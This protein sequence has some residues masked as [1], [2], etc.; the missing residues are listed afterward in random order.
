MVNNELNQFKNLKYF[1][2]KNKIKNLLVTKINNSE[3]KVTSNN[4]THHINYLI[5]N[6]TYC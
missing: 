3:Y 6:C 2:D 4:K 5:G 1:I